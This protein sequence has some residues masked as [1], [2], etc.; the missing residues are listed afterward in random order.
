[1]PIAWKKNELVDY[2]IKVHSNGGVEGKHFKIAVGLDVM[3]VCLSL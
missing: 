2:K 3:P 1:M